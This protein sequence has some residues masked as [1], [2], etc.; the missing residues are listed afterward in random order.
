MVRDRS[1]LA[2]LGI[3]VTTLE[4]GMMRTDMPGGSSMKIPPISEPYLGS[5][6]AIADHLRGK[7]MEAPVDPAKVA[8][9]SVD[10]TRM[11][12]P[13]TRLLLGADA[14]TLANAAAKDLF[15]SDKSWLALSLSVDF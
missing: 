6:G 13:P 14:V 15:E 3:K 9:L 7:N 5:V 4:P 1:E 8:R 2:P 10:L 11:D 12:E